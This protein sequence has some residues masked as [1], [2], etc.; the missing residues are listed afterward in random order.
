MTSI[1]SRVHNIKKGE[2]IQLCIL[3]W[4]HVVYTAHKVHACMVGNPAVRLQGQLSGTLVSTTWSGWRSSKPWVRWL[5][6][7][8]ALIGTWHRGFIQTILWVRYLF[9]SIYHALLIVWKRHFLL[10]LVWCVL[11]RRWDLWYIKSVY[12][13]ACMRVC[14][15]VCVCTRA[16][17]CVCV[18]VC[19]TCLHECMLAWVRVCVCEA[20]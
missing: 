3:L 5:R 20:A 12:F 16:F 11:W 10:R 4:M 2:S 19:A 15:C 7:T 14:V 8:W 13:W 18:C 9:L 6:S 17:V 1:I